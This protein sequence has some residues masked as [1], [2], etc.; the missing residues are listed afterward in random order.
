[1]AKMTLILK[2]TMPLLPEAIFSL[3]LVR[4]LTL[5]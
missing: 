5:I 3:A 4:A 1:M 2:K